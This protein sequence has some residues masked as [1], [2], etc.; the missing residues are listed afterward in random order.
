M[1]TITK[2]KTVSASV[3]RIFAVTLLLAST[4]H[5]RSQGLCQAAFTYTLSSGNQVSVTNTSTGTNVNTLYQWNYGD[6]T[7]SN[8]Q[9]PSS[10]TYT[11]NGR[12]YIMLNIDS[13]NGGC[14]S[15]AIDSVII[16]GGTTCTLNTAFTYTAGTSGSYS[17][18]DVSTG[19]TPG[20]SYVWSYQGA[21]GAGSSSLQN[22]TFV[23]NYNGTYTVNFS[24]SYTG[25]I[26]SQTTT[27]VVTVTN[28]QPCQVSFTYTLGAGGQVTT[29]NTSIG[30][31]NY[32]WSF[33]DNSA[34]VNAASPSHTYIYNGNYYISM[35]ADTSNG[36]CGGMAKDSVTITGLQN[37]PSC[38][39]SFTYTQGS[40][41]AINFT[42]TSSGT[43]ASPSYSWDFGDGA[44]STSPSPSHTYT[45]NGNF[46]VTI[47]E[48]DTFNTVICQNTQ[49]IT[50]S[51]STNNTAC[52]TLYFNVSPDTNA[53][54]VWNVYLYTSSGNTPAGAV[55]Y[56]GDGTNTSGI[57]PSHTY[58]AAG[59]YNICVMAW[60]NCGDSTYVCQ[61][62][63]V[64]RTNSMISVHVINETT[65]TGVKNISETITSAVAYPNPFSDE[66]TIN[67]SSP[68]SKTV[69]Y[70]MTDLYG[71]VLRT[72]TIQAVKGTNELKLNTGSMAQGVYFVNLVGS[73]DVKASVI[74]V[75]K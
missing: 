37:P 52:D 16:T 62:D 36:A 49:M 35:W 74:K 19:E 2:T 53:L 1:K 41:G 28:S 48:K 50:V 15:Q 60:F 72:G 51:T 73:G 66:L 10:H 14:S 5:M 38:T 43:V 65:A 45:Y 40:G 46:Y 23:F 57:A 58:A 31:S 54:H 32:Y 71:K 4:A 9:N 12:Y 26:C 18:S 20:M 61:S 68:A 55:W 33:G 63:S 42:N 59:L 47:Y 27:S 21:N 7:Y 75:V 11:Y 64:Y 67:F 29:T 56:W 44:T 8:A 6:G 34:T 17:F 30:N 13:S 69:S 70:S 3:K 22:P 24:V 25:G 39:A